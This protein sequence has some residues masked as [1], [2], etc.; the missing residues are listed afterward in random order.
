MKIL[1]TPRSV[2]RTHGHP[3]LK[4]L[5]DA[6]YEVVFSTP[7]TLPGEDELLKLLP[8][9]IGYLAGV[10]KISAKV[11]NTVSDLRVISRNGTG[12]DSIDLEA[13]ERSGIA[14]CRAAGANARGV[15]E[16]TFGLIL[17]LIRSIPFSDAAMKTQRWVRREGIE[18]AGRT[19]GLIG[20]GVVGKY[21]AKLALGFDMN[22][23]ACDP[24]PDYSFHPGERFSYARMDE[25]LERSDIISLH[26][27]PMADGKPLVD[28]AMIGRMKNGVYL[29]NTARGSLLDQ[30]AALAALTSGKISGI[31]VDAFDPEPPE[32]WRITLDPRVI[33]TPHIGGYTGESIE[34]AMSVAV[35]NLLHALVSAKNVAQARKRHE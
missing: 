31:G 34:R 7:G 23:L 9:C 15:A 18:V 29:V 11:L 16:L 12:V 2:T 35:D 21:V 33:A 26:C 32:D 28:A 6:G 5:E 20:C 25:L 1:V 4:P 3:S 10:E 8:G 22:V 17:S 13:A 30:D 24:Y 14:V 27:P 19:L